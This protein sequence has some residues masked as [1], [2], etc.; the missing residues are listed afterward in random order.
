MGG[1]KNA[2]DFSGRKL[3]LKKKSGA[4]VRWKMKRNALQ[5][6]QKGKITSLRESVKSRKI[7]WGHPS[8]FP[9]G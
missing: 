6:K 8:K 9:N 5:E 2:M 7:W 4:L 3:Y 1:Q